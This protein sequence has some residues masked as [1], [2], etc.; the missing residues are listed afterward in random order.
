M[1]GEK[2]HPAG[3]IS[4][5]HDFPSEIDLSIWQPRITYIKNRMLSKEEIAR[6]NAETIRSG[7][8]YEA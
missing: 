5:E 2:A 7:N 3:S 1:R 6:P 8:I 4:I